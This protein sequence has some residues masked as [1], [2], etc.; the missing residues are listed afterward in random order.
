MASSRSLGPSPSRTE[1]ITSV[2]L[3]SHL[4]PVDTGIVLWIACWPTGT[5]RVAVVLIGILRLYILQ[6]LATLLPIC[7]GSQIGLD[8][9][10]GT[11]RASC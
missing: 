11:G 1:V 3:R 9:T 6:N 4:I 8:G 2:V 10:Y 7:S 5:Y